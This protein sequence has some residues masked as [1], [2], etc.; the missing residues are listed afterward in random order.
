MPRSY[1]QAVK[2]MY[3]PRFAG[4]L[5]MLAMAAQGQSP[6][7]ALQSARAAAERGV[8]AGQLYV[9]ESYRDGDGVPQ[10]YKEA[11]HWFRLAADQGNA[12]AQFNLGY[13]YFAGQGVTQDHKEAVRWYRMAAEQ[14]MEGAQNNLGYAYRTGD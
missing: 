5:F 14:G 10:D 11:A 12:L 6:Q 1:N 7:A 4:L 8:A 9:G 2:S 3:N 13:L